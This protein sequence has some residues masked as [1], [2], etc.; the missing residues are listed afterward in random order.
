M[1]AALA[2]D[3]VAMVLLIASTIV[4]VGVALIALLVASLVVPQI[5]L[6]GTVDTSAEA[7]AASVLMVVV[8]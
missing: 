6:V 4:C 2:H 8:N 5:G 3:F 7:I 1:R